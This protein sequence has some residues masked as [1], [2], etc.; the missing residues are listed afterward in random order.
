MAPATRARSVDELTLP[1]VEKIV[2]QDAELR[3][4]LVDI[5][6]RQAGGASTGG[7]YNKHD[8]ARLRF[9]RD[10]ALVDVR[11]GK[12]VDASDLRMLRLPPQEELRQRGGADWHS[13][14]TWA[15]RHGRD[16]RSQRKDGWLDEQ[17]QL[18]LLQWARCN[19]AYFAQAQYARR[20]TPSLYKLDFDAYSGYTGAP[21]L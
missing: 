7:R 14:E 2:E 4:I 15:E 3:Q 21:G 6:R 12:L 11:R 9:V 1:E 18:T 20:G 17:Q 16:P 13:M 19:T 8:T 10:K 5:A